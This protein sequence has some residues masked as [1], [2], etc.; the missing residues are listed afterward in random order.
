M[1]RTVA[2][3]ILMVLIIIVFRVV[4]CS[5]D[6]I[7]KKCA[8]DR[9]SDGG[10][11]ECLLSEDDICSL[12]RTPV[13]CSNNMALYNIAND[14]IHHWCLSYQGSDW[15]CS[16]TCI[17]NSDCP[18]GFKCSKGFASLDPELRETSFC[19]PKQNLECIAGTVDAG[20]TSTTDGGE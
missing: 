7:G 20:S 19:V 12:P 2:M 3:M 13:S 6:D 8:V 10:K 17:S 14:C 1:N 5:E 18:S 9:T 16:R 11:S 4:A 15:F